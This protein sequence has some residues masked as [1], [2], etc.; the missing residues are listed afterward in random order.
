MDGEWSY[1]TPLPEWALPPEG[2]VGPTVPTE[3]SDPA[4]KL[5][6]LGLEDSKESTQEATTS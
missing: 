3:D 6:K 1:E 5:A 2:Y 4:A